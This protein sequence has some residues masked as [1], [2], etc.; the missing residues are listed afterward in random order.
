MQKSSSVPL[1]NA[2]FQAGKT[3]GHMHEK[4]DHSYSL[5]LYR[6]SGIASRT[7]KIGIAGF[8][9]TMPIFFQGIKSFSEVP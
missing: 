2:L 1:W 3:A 7:E 8:L 4:S 5:E 9:R 6:G